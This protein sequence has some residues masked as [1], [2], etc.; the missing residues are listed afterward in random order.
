VIDDGST[1]GTADSVHAE[2]PEV[3]VLCGDGY[4]WWTGAIARGM[5]HALASEECEA[6]FWLND[7]CRPAAGTLE[8]LRT[9]ALAGPR[10]AIAQVGSPAGIRFGGLRRHWQ[11]LALAD[12]GPDVVVSVDTM[13]G[14]CV[15]VPA[16]CARRVGP[17]DAV[18]FPQ[19]YGDTDFGLRCRRAGFE[20]VVVGAAVC[21]DVEPED[22]DKS[23]WLHGDRSVAEIARSFRS[24]KNYFFPPPWWHFCVRHW[25]AWGAA[26][27]VAPY[28]RFCLIALLRAVTPPSLRRRW[29]AL[30][31]PEQAVR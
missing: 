2:F 12:C 16:V 21:H 23:S 20:V 4:L 15:C 3:H 7:D 6:I 1:D 13:N 10:V 28:L 18:H 19:A 8:R 26:L 27:F 9:E 31:R 25:G 24:P 14:N 5:A 22:R 11:G 17:P 29:A 30:R